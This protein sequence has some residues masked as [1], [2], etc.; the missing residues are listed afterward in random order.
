M[1]VDKNRSISFVCQHS[2]LVTWLQAMRPTLL[3][4]WSYFPNLDHV[5][6]SKDAF[7]YAFHK[8]A[9]SK[10][11]KPS[12]QL[13]FSLPS[14][15]ITITSNGRK[16]KKHK[17]DRN[18]PITDHKPWLS[19]VLFPKRSVKMIGCSKNTHCKCQ[20]VFELRSSRV[21]EKRS[22]S[23]VHVRVYSATFERN[24]L[25]DNV[26]WSAMGKQS[27]QAKK[28]YCNY[29]LGMTCVHVSPYLKTNYL[30]L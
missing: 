9:N 12:S 21:F 3:A 27:L 10:V 29:R 30:K 2:C 18:L 15:I 19:K 5:T 8:H 7:Y 17:T 11:Q 22:K 20:L 1:L 25:W 4:L 16:K 28:G 14:I 26:T 23:C 24:S 6:F 13:R